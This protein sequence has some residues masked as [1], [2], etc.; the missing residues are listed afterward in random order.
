M[1]LFVDVLPRLRCCVLLRRVIHLLLV[2][3]IVV[4]GLST[5]LCSVDN[6]K[7]P[8]TKTLMAVLSL[9]TIA[10]EKVRF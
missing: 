3:I 9:V 7:L 5:R 6:I 10:K 4:S 8:S 2:D 1:G